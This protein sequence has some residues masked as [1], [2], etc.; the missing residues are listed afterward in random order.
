[1][2]LR[3]LGAGPVMTTAECLV[4][5]LGAVVIGCGLAVAIAVALSPM[6]PI[7]AVRP[8]YPERGIA[9]DWTVLGSGF[10]LLVVVLTSVAVLIARRV[11]HQRPPNRVLGARGGSP[12][13]RAATAAGLPPAALTGIRAAVG[14]GAG[15]DAAPVRSALAGAVLAVVVVVASITFGTSLDALVSHPPLYGW[16]WN[17]ALLS[18]Y[19]AAED[20]PGAQT[21]ALLDHDRSIARFAGVYFLSLQLDG[22]PVPVLATRPDAPVG[23]P[24]LSGHGLESARQVVLGTSTLAELHKHVGDTVVA[25]I[26]RPSADLRILRIVGTATLP[27]I[28]GSGNPNLQMGSGAVVSSSLFPPADLDQQG[29]PIPG[30]MAELITIRPGASPAEA[31][32][33]L[34]RITQVLNQGPDGPIGGVVSVL[35]PAAIANY[36]TVGSTPLW[37]A[38]ILAAGAIA[39]LGLTLIASVRRRRREFA[40]L[41]AF[42]FTRAQVATTVAWHASVSATVGVIFGVPLGIALGRWLWTLFARGISAVPDPTVPVLS[43]VL[44][45]IGAVVFA[46]LVATIPGTVAARSPTALLLRSE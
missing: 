21:A 9:F 5:V 1:M 35:R 12:T 13:V 29:S 37:L 6:A 18:G 46:N 43:V 31:L 26:G 30:P 7:G 16:N 32:R 24:L 42:G 34:D 27:T 40:L 45:V 8:V 38:G 3:A 25:Q 28:G 17:Y 10:A 14:A 22:Q 33:S 15:R 41:K 44:V 19:S 23:P 36:R 11:S 39:A 4:G 20:L 2:I